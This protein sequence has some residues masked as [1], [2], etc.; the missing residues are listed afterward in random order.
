ME[1]PYDSQPLRMDNLR[2]LKGGGGKDEENENASIQAL[3]ESANSLLVEEVSGTTLPM[4]VRFLKKPRISIKLPS[5]AGGRL[6][7]LTA[8]SVLGLFN[9]REKRPWKS[10]FLREKEKK[11]KKSW[12]FIRE[13]DPTRKKGNRKNFFF[14]FFFLLESRRQEAM[15]SEIRDLCCPVES[16]FIFI[17]IVYLKAHP[18]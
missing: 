15:E 13:G 1:S 6:H 17:F 9:K 2:L 4:P 18:H 11:E 16:D 7:A 5:S 3:G 8:A 14:L 12:L 10:F